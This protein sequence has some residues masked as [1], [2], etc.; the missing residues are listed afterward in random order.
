MKT[1]EVHT[2][3]QALIIVEAESE[4]KAMI[5]AEE[6]G[7]AAFEG[8]KLGGKVISAAREATEVDHG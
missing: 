3:I 8:M 2:T 7:A 5:A 1:Y 4:S 6:K